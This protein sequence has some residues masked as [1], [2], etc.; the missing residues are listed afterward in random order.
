MVPE[1]YPFAMNDDAVRA[2]LDEMLET[3][4]ARY[5]GTSFAD[6]LPEL[7]LAIVMTGVQELSRRETAQ[8]RASTDQAAQA[9]KRASKSALVVATLA[10]AVSVGGLIVAIISVLAN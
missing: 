8:L 4:P 10:L 2:A 5:A 1:D 9:A 6:A 3:T 7:K